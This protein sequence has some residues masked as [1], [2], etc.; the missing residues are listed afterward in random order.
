M[1]AIA[2]FTGDECFQVRENENIAPIIFSY[3][4]F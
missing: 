3:L 1:F 2:I 4:L